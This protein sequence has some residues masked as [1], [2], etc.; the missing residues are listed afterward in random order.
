MADVK[1]AVV[2]TDN[3]SGTDVR[4]ELVSVKYMGADGNTATDLDNGHVVKLAGLMAGEREIFKA[5][6]VTG[7]EQLS[8]VYFVAS[9]EVN[10][11]CGEYDLTHFYNEANMPARGYGLYPNGFLSVTKEALA[12]EAVPAV[13]HSVELAAGTKMNVVAAPTGTNTLIGHIIAIE[14]VGMYTFY[15]IKLGK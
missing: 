3:L 10:Y 13:G 9:P 2:R 5:V 6:D 7:T 8:E 11:R 15:V 1:H 12:G 14:T 4:A